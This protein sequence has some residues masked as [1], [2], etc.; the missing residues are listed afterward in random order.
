MKLILRTT[1]LSELQT[2]I[3]GKS[4]VSVEAVADAVILHLSDETRL[5]IISQ[6]WYDGGFVFEVFQ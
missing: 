1:E 2:I 4:I 6:G 3:S 5:E